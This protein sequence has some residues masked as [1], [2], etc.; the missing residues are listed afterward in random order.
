MPE[1]DNNIFKKRKTN[2]DSYSEMNWVWELS[3]DREDPFARPDKW[4]VPPES[5]LNWDWTGPS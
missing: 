5:L 2:E 4:K 3:P 1:E